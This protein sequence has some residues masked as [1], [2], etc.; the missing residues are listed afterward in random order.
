MITVSP[1]CRG[2]AFK[3]A[4]Q[5]NPSGPLRQQRGARFADITAEFDE[6][7]NA[8]LSVNF[9][10]FEEGVTT[11]D[12]QVC[13]LSPCNSDKISSR[14]L[15]RF[16]SVLSRLMTYRGVD[17]FLRSTFSCCDSVFRHISFLRYNLRVVVFELSSGSMTRS[18]DC[19]PTYLSCF[20]IQD[21]SQDE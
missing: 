20:A 1:V 15:F 2:M 14:R 21:F 4:V 13:R 9:P 11:Y 19:F 12:T 18:T 16:M 17:S 5:I 8:S 7:F 6:Q 10:I 3:S